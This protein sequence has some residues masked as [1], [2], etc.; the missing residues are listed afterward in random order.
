MVRL[1]RLRVAWIPL[2]LCLLSATAD[3]QVFKY[4]KPDGTVVYTDKLSDLPKKRRAYYNKLLEEQKKKRRELEERIGKEEL[5]RQEAE[6]ERRALVDQQIAAAD[7]QRRIQEIDAQLEAIRKRRKTREDAKAAWANRMKNAHKRQADLLAEFRKT[8]KTYE[9][10]AIK[11]SFTL[12]PG[13]AKKKEDLQKKLRQLE[14][15]LDATIHEVNVVIPT[16]AR[17]A[18]VPPGWLR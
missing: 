16:E 1:R 11:P 2:G 8:Q 7:R 3:G 14:K 18:G 4:R 10:I 5:D 9:A 15:E 13:E 12:F 17:K 6:R